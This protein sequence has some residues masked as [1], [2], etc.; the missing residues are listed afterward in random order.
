VGVS[1]VGQVVGQRLGSGLGV[2]G[3]GGLV[4]GLARVGGLS[5]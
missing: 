2:T 4:A 1:V 5:R 3:V